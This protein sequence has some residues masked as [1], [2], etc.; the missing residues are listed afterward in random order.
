[1]RSD[2]D[3]IDVK[4]DVNSREEMVSIIWLGK[5]ISE[6]SCWG[7]RWLTLKGGEPIGGADSRV[8]PTSSPQID[9]RT[10]HARLVSGDILLYARE[11]VRRRKEGVCQED[12]KFKGISFEMGYSLTPVS[13]MQVYFVLTSRT[14]QGLYLRWAAFLQRPLSTRSSSLIK[15]KF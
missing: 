15:R 8:V 10:I 3:W 6:R 7:L 4:S 2:Q 14:S 1:M 9:T 11:E 12:T 13:L 5:E